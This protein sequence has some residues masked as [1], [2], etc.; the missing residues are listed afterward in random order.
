MNWIEQNQNNVI[1]RLKVQPRARETIIIGLHG[2]PAR[3]KIKLA[4]P[5]VD[6]KAN[7]ELLRFFKVLL[8]GSFQKV[9][10]LRGE[11]SSLK[12]LLIAGADRDQI[13]SILEPLIKN[14][15]QSL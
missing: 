12:D 11:K 15:T 13:E 10:L 14:S 6:G 5:P 7:E 9:E 4:A 3:I 1:I 8:K 2:D